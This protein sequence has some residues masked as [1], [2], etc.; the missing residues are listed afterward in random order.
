MLNLHY[1]KVDFL[2]KAYGKLFVILRTLSDKAD[3][4]THDSYADFGDK[5]ANQSSKIV[6]KMLETSNDWKDMLFSKC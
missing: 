4:E 6:L 1:N 3:G 5:A 2:E